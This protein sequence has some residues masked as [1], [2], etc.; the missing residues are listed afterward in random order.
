MG[1]LPSQF[2][3]VKS[4]LYQNFS[5]VSYYEKFFIAHLDYFQVEFWSGTDYFFTLTS[6]WQGAVVEKSPFKT[7]DTRF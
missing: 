3:N 4:L 7:A 2:G 1:A 5:N 6:V